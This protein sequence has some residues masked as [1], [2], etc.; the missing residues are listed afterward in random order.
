MIEVSRICDAETIRIPL[1]IPSRFDR[2]KSQAGIEQLCH[3]D[4]A[5][6]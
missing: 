4:E 1:L 2:I 6:D 3:Y 5:V